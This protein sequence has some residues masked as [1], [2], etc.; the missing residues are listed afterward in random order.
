MKVID[1]SETIS[2]FAVGRMFELEREI[3]RKSAGR[4]QNLE[5]ES[6]GD[7]VLI[8]GL[9][10]TYYAKQLATQ[11]VLDQVGDIQLT[12]DIVVR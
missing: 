7:A 2:M 11:V 8:S 5:V 1:Q 3:H 12:N 6:T 9:T 10:N 4:I